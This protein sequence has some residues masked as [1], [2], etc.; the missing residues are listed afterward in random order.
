MRLNTVIRLPDGREGTICY[1]NLDGVGGVWGRH[2]FTMPSGG[3]GDGLPAPEFMLREPEMQGRVGAPESE[4]VGEDYEVIASSEPAEET[5]N[6]LGCGGTTKPYGNF[7]TKEWE[8]AADPS[9][10][11]FNMLVRDAAQ[12]PQP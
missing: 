12:E 5:P 8:C 6:C 7:V 2:T 4:C 11:A 3:F 9:C 10:G 1:H